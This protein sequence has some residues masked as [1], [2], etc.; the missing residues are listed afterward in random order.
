MMAGCLEQAERQTNHMKNGSNEGQ[1]INPF[2]S[3]SPSIYLARTLL[4]ALRSF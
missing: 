3:V 1:N 4:L 2:H